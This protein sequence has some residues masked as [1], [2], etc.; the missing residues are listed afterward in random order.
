VLLR[1]TCRSPIAGCRTCTGFSGGPPGQNLSGVFGN[2]SHFKAQI[3]ITT[4]FPR[5]V[6]LFQAMPGFPVWQ[7]RVYLPPEG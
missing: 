1:G 2:S 7:G 6:L 4:A 3:V 5:H